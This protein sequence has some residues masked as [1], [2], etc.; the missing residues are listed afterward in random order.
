M[1]NDF[2]KEE[3]VAFEEILAGFQ[4]AEVMSKNVMKYGTDQQMMERT[5]DIIWRPQPYVMNSYDGLDQTANFADKTQLSVPA[6]INISKSVPYTL[7]AKEL[8]DQLQEGRL[9]D[10]AKQ[11]L[12]SD[13]NVAILE[14][15]CNLGS[16]VVPIADSA[17]GFDDVAQVEAIMNE[18]GVQAFDRILALNTRDYNGMAS[19]LANRADISAKKSLTAYE[20]AYI[21]QI[22]S[23][24]T[25]KLDYSKRL[26]AAAGGAITI[27][28]T[29][30]GNFLTPKATD[31][32]QLGKVNVDNRYQT[33]TVSSTTDVAAGDCFTITGVEAVHQITKEATG[34]LKTFRVV[35]VDTATTMTITPPLIDPDSGAGAES[36][37][38]YQNVDVTTASATAAIN[39]LNTVTTGIN[40]FF[41]KEALEILPGRLA[42]PSDSGMKVMRG[43]TDSG[44][45]LVMSKQSDINGLDTKFRFDVLFGVVNKAP[46]MSGILLFGQT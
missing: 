28:T 9:G 44:L 24:D 16:L 20:R 11:K 33:V 14:T 12:A 18:Q 23:F 19:N 26:T 43:T 8:R 21:G 29:A 27:D 41:Q 37:K 6:S 31:A 1:S 35:S 5:N 4:D 39:W 15:A 7:T 40:P 3:R 13:I 34:Q 22:C 25:W 46:E 42:I 36:E 10:G 30:A 45:E 38:Q 2:S 32:T 17:S